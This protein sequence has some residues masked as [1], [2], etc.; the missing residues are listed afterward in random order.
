MRHGNGFAQVGR[1][2]LFTF[3]H[4]RN[5]LWLDIAALHQLLTGKANGLLFI[6]G[7]QAEEH[8]AFT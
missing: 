7:L 3:Q 1:S 5:I 8:V 4:G 2:Q 6:N